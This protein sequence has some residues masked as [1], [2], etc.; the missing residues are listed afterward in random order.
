MNNNV[1]FP[2]LSVRTFDPARVENAQSPMSASPF[3][4]VVTVDE[5][6][7]PPVSAKRICAAAIGWPAHT[8]CVLTGRATALSVAH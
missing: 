4:F 1:A 7:P 2:M 6:E 3:A 8:E 5:T